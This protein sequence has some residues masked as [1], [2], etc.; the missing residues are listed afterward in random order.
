[1][2][3]PASTG[4]LPVLPI[5]RSACAVTVV[6]VVDELLIGL[7]SAV[8]ELTV[9]VL[10]IDPPGVAGLTC[11]TSVKF[12]VDPAATLALSAVTGPVAPTAGV[13]AAQP[14]GAVNDTNVVF[15]GRTSLS[16][17]VAA[18]LGPLFVTL[19]V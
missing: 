1:M 8:G 19:S 4:P 17:T 3:D 16:D 11:T 13:V 2:F 15:G 12:E 10:L 14:A 18:L 5:D 7:G 6:V 9:A